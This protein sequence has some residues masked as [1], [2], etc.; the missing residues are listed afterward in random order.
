MTNVLYFF[1]LDK[2][3][4]HITEEGL[5]IRFFLIFEVNE[6]LLRNL[7]FPVDRKSSNEYH[8]FSSLF[9]VTLSLYEGRL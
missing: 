8:L 4:K 3:N 7:V 9:S 5:S 6:K 2:L 1:A